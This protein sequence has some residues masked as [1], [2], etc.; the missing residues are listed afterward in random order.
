MNKTNVI[1]LLEA[2]DI[3]HEIK[4]YEVN[5]DDLSGASVAQK[6]G[7]GEEIVFKTLVAEGDKTGLIVFC[8]PVNSELNLK[9]AAAVSKNKKV[10]LIPTKNL[11]AVT[12]YV[13][14]GCSP[15]GMKKKFPT[16]I[17]KTAQL[18]DKIYFSA[19]IRGMQFGVHPDALQMFT[20][21]IFIDLT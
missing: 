18:F 3:P 5:E 13:R 11:L 17:D 10:E 15:I 12:G 2:N 7:A 9:K 19:G 4:T 14:G 21:S 6:I 1:R 20:S 16:Y 8:I